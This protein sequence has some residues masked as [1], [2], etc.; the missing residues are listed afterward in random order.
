MKKVLNQAGLIVA[1]LLVG[2]PTD[3]ATSAEPTKVAQAKTKTRGQVTGTGESS[4]KARNEAESNARDLA[5]GNSYTVI[6][7][8]TT[9][10]GKNWTCTLTIEYTPK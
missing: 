3:Q 10:S 2:L 1:L 7:S 4:F 8:N 9:G 6:K 5:G